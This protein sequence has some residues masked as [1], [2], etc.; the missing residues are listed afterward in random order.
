MI[1]DDFKFVLTEKNNILISYHQV[2]LITK[3]EDCIYS[4]AFHALG[5][6]PVTLS[7]QIE[8]HMGRSEN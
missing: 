6:L 8:K 5:V 7:T 4:M 1:Y 2:N 3:E